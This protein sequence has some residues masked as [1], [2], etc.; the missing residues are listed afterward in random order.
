M[1]GGFAGD[2]CL[3]ASL[4]EKRIEKEGLRMSLLGASSIQYHITDTVGI[5]VEPEI[6]GRYLPKAEYFTPI[7]LSTPLCLLSQQD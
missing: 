7:V 1:G 5:C 4:R 6:V 2:Y 3:A